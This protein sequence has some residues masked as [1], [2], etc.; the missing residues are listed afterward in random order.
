MVIC[1]ICGQPLTRSPHSWH[2]ENKHS[3][4]VARQGYVNLLP[5]QQKHS[6]APGD[7]REMVSAR[8][9]FLDRGYYLPIA[10]QLRRLV[11]P[12]APQCIL[13]AGCGEGYYLSHLS[14][15]PERWGI[16]ISKE[17]VRFAAARDKSTHWL[18]ATAAHLP[19]QDTTFDGVLSMFAFTALAE[20]ARVLKPSG[21]FLQVLAGKSHLTELKKIIYPEIIEKE[22]NLQPELHGFTLKESHTLE[23]SFHLHS[24]DEIMQLFS[25]TPHIHRIGKGGAQALAQTR[26]LTDQAQVI[27]NVYQVDK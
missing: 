18:T 20:F 10:E 8:R 23:F 27:F 2:C 6:I 4:D 22:K 5:V 14:D 11:K 9:S 24:N 3:F 26:E 25:M 16:D 12:L 17:A 15:I 21:F 13:D 19:F 7:S 1:P